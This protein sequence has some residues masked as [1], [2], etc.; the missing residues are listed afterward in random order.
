MCDNLIIIFLNSSREFADG[1]SLI[2][3]SSVL[4]CDN[5]DDSNS[6]S[7][8]LKERSTNA[9]TAVVESSEDEAMDS[10]ETGGKIL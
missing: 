1:R 7:N 6:K 10:S 3:M 9:S 2:L 8:I 5:K 4:R